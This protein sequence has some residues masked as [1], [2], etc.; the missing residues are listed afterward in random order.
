MKRLTAVSVSKIKEIMF[1]FKAREL[2]TFFP[3]HSYVK[4]NGMLSEFKEI[5]SAHE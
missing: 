4:R 1:F 3:N 5:K 2:W